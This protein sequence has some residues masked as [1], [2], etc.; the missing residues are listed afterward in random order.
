MIVAMAN[1]KGAGEATTAQTL[2][3]GLVERE[4]KML[5]INL[6]PQLY[7]LKG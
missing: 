6:S 2:V 3:V 4:Y 1:Q 7:F 5:G